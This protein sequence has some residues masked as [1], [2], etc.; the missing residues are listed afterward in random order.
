MSYPSDEFDQP[1]SPYDPYEANSGHS[2]SWLDEPVR[3]YGIPAPVPERSNHRLRNRAIAVVAAVATAAG[4]AAGGLTVF[5]GSSSVHAIGKTPAAAGKLR[6]G[7]EPTAAVMPN[8]D[9]AACVS[10]VDGETTLNLACAKKGFGSVLSPAVTRDLGAIVTINLSVP[11]EYTA[12]QKQ[13]MLQQIQEDGGSTSGQFGQAYSSITLSGE[14]V[15]YNG[16]VE[17]VTAGHGNEIFSEGSCAGDGESTVAAGGSVAKQGFAV[18]LNS[19]QTSYVNTKQETAGDIDFATV[20]TSGSNETAYNELPA[21]PAEIE[22]QPKVGEL[23]EAL[24]EEPNYN[25][26]SDQEQNSPDASQRQMRV[27]N[28]VY[29]GQDPA[30]PQDGVFL[31]LGAAEGGQGY[32]IGGASGSAIVSA[33]NGDEEAVLVRGQTEADNSPSDNNE[34]PYPITAAEFNAEYDTNLVGDGTAANVQ[35]IIGQFL[36]AENNAP[37]VDCP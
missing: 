1:A 19:F 5:K 22:A 24:T 11:I 12:A 29:A 34:I 33:E 37:I 4:L 26:D 30:D 8:Y 3:S 23:F 21:I 32:V 17:T 10:E 35:P 31:P 2:D 16:T 9:P 20:T 28:L 7:H 25:G 6:P 18:N 14:R 36:P 27:I 15:D 13:Q